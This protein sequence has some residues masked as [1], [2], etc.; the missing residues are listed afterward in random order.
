MH[1][2]AIELAN[3][4]LHSSTKCWKLCSWIYQGKIWNESSDPNQYNI[5]NYWYNMGFPRFHKQI[6]IIGIIWFILSFQWDFPLQRW[7]F[8]WI[9]A[10]RNDIFRYLKMLFAHQRVLCVCSR[11]LKVF[12]HL[13]FQRVSEYL[14]KHFLSLWTVVYF[15]TLIQ[16]MHFCLL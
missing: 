11:L 8:D 6:L 1:L 4:I 12:K 3:I 16:C 13:K 5:I 14:Q 2:I 15:L 9:R 7:R 10:P